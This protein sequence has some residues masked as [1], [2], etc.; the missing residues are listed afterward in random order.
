MGT[1]ISIRI[2]ECGAGVRPAKM[3]RRWQ[4]GNDLHWTTH[5]L[6]GA[7]VGFLI[8][9]PVPAFLAGFAGHLALDTFPHHDPDSDIPYI[10]DSVTGAAV[11]AFIAS[12][13]RVREAD[14]R[15][16]ALFGAIG[17]GLPDVELLRK[18]FSTV[19]PEDYFFPSHN[20]LVPHRQMGMWCSGVSQVALVGVCM[21]LVVRKLRRA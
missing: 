19:E 18:L 9:K 14:P 6:T 1:D 4:K 20:G 8:E 15:H 5:V 21:L 10:V 7:A 3:P 13:R 2:Y 16:S 11:V 17:G 12:S